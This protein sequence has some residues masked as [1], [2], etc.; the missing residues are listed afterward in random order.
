MALRSP[1][2]C[3]PVLGGTDPAETS[4]SSVTICP[5]ST[6]EGEAEP[7]TL[8]LVLVRHGLDAFW[9]LDG[10][11]SSKSTMLLPVS[12]C[13]AAPPGLRSYERSLPSTVSTGRG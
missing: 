6:G 4:A 12:S 9:G 11:I 13:P 3:R 2:T 7:L 8:G 10:E 1:A 5:C